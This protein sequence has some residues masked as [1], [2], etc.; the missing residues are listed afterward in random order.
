M[1]NN[2]EKETTCSFCGKSQDAVERIIIG[3]GVNICS[4]CIELCST[5][6]TEEGVRGR[7]G[8]HQPLRRG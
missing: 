5:L 4:E 2:R 8:G 1:A 3:P 6:L 7:S